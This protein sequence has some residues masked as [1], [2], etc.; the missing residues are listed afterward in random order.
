[1]QT[2]H[3]PDDST[4]RGHQEEGGCLLPRTGSSGEI[5]PAEVSVRHTRAVQAVMEAACSPITIGVLIG[6][7]TVEYRRSTSVM[8]EFL[9]Q[10]WQQN[11]GDPGPHGLPCGTLDRLP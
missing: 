11:G 3:K 9:P 2:L 8:P 1:M 10:G 7:L 4:H 5:C 6:K